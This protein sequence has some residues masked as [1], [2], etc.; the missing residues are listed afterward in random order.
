[1]QGDRATEPCG[2]RAAAAHEDELAV[3]GLG[4]GQALHAEPAGVLRVARL[5]ELALDTAATTQTVEPCG[6]KM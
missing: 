5:A 6:N 4:A 2:H 1:M 3:G